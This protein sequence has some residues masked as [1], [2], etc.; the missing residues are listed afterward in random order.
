MGKVEDLLNS[1]PEPSYKR[2]YYKEAT[3]LHEKAQRG[4]KFEENG[5]WGLKD[6][7]GSIIYEANCV[8]IGVCKDYVL[9]IYPDGSYIKENSNCRQSGRL[10]E[11][12]RPYV[13]NGKAGFKVDD[14]VIIPPEYDFIEKLFG[15]TV[16]YAV[17]DGKE[18]YLNDEG[19]EVLTRVRHFDGED[20]KHSPFWLCSNDMDVVTFMNYV[21]ERDESN[22][23]VVMIRGQWIEL[24]RYCKDEILAMLI[25]P[26]DDLA[27]SEET[28]KLFCNK[29]SYEYSFYTA[30][31]QGKSALKDCVEQFKKMNVF[32]NSWYYIVKIWQAPNEQLKAQDLRRFTNAIEKNA[33][34]RG[35]IGTPIFAVGHSTELEPGEVRVLLITHY[36]ERCW[37]AQFE[38]VWSDY[39]RSLPITKL[40][41]EIPALR[42]SVK[43]E[44]QPENQEEV[45][46]DQLLNCI[47]GLK[48]YDGLHWE[49]A[50]KALNSFA[51]L[52]SPIRHSLRQYLSNVLDYCKKKNAQEAI[53]F[54]LKAAHWALQKGDIVND[55]NKKKST[56]DIL[57]NIKAKVLNDDA[58][59]LVATLEA[60]L[61]S[62]GAKTFK[63]LELERN[64]N[65]D[66]F[67]ELD[68]LR[69]DGT[70]EKSMPGLNSFKL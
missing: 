37:P 51:Q 19:K 2:E 40:L 50:E 34:E 33:R 59:S 56:L 7:D 49:D 21:G 70:S 62:K 8:F 53:L 42:G 44:I 48:Y 27:I 28:L 54:F 68:Y 36:H 38:Y 47:V 13:V 17:K 30:N 55:C 32:Y 46:N 31:A 29:F 35:I 6:I 64:S 11:N 61:L 12:K 9:A 41:E 25:D 5:L 69:I 3:S 18:M 1:L 14:K 43:E 60:E 15:D 67:K 39:C 58:Q 45:F 63:E 52:G 4:Y 26:S 23:N 65:S 57:Q 16:F 10:D 22:P 66:Y 24:E 20:D